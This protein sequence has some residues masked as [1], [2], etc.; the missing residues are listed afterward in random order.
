[1]PGK[2][3]P[4]R[5]RESEIARTVRAVRKG[6][7]PVKHVTVTFTPEGTMTIECGEAPTSP[8]ASPDA[9]PHTST[10]VN[11]WDQDLNGKNTPPLR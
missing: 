9:S 1:M 5:F 11:E 4:C 3:K 10:D 7:V 8:G 6:G 2:R